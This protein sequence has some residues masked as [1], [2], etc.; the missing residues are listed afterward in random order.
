[1]RRHV[2]KNHQKMFITTAWMNRGLEIEKSELYLHNFSYIYLFFM[3]HCKNTM[4]KKHSQVLYF[5]QVYY[6]H[7]VII[8]RF[9]IYL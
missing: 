2:C 9:F 6:H 1:M 7:K 5:F 3:F 4:H 8:H